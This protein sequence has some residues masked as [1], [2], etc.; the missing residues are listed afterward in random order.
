M[1]EPTAAAGLSSRK[2]VSVCHLK[3]MASFSGF[4]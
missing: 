1:T 2:D 4:K 3:I